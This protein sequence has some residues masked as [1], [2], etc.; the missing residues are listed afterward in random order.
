MRRIGITGQSGTGK[1]AVTDI[2]LKKGAVNV[3]ADKIAHEIIL[4]GKPA[5]NELVEYF[6]DEILDE[7]G[8]IARKKLGSIVFA[9]G[10]EKLKFLNECTHKHIFN[11]MKRQV[12]EAEKNNEEI[13][14]I[15]APLL[16][17]E[18]FITLTKEIWVVHSEKSVQIARIMKRDNISE[19]EAINRL[20]NQ[21]PFSVYESFATDIIEN[22]TDLFDLEK[23]IE[24]ALNKK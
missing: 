10:K 2:L 13:V 19:E 7:N 24:R 3:D 11:E 8:E 23:E 6:G 5:Y 16:I 14:V 22:S 20:N 1:S 12:E 9:D 15:D 18:P 17:E 4:K 21:K